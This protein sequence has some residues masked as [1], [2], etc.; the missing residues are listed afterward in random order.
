MR[1]T[2]LKSCFLGAALFLLCVSTQAATLNFAGE[3]EQ[4]TGE[5]RLFLENSLE[6]NTFAGTFN[7]GEPLSISQSGAFTLIELGPSSFTYLGNTLTAQGGR[8]LQAPH[9]IYGQQSQ[10]STFGATSLNGTVGGHAFVQAKFSAFGPN[11]FAQPDAL[12]NFTLN[13]LAFASIFLQ[14]G[15]PFT[16]ITSLLGRTGNM[17]F[18]E[19]VGTIPVPAALPLL[20]SSLLGLGVLTRQ[21]RNS[22]RTGYLAKLPPNS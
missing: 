4:L 5:P 18:A 15:T 8:I 19:A 7:V 3:F 16:G 6:R 14:V 2:A 22:E 20:I 12:P 9:A 13:E 11:L 10:W 21:R 17:E 1:L